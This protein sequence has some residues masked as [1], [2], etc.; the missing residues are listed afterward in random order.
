MKNIVWIRWY[1]LYADG[2]VPTQDNEYYY[3][4]YKSENRSLGELHS[5]IEADLEESI[6]TFEESDLY[7]C[8]RWEYIDKPPASYIE[9]ELEGLKRRIRFSTEMVEYLESLKDTDPFNYCIGHYWKGEDGAISV[10]AYGKEVHYGSLSDATK[11]LEYVRGQ[12]PDHNWTIF[13]LDELAGF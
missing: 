2:V 10:Y 11:F 8:F 9:Q 7:R 6:S 1:K 4:W 5:I 12:S 13:K 3:Q